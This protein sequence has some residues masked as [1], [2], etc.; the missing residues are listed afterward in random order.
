MC[1]LFMVTKSSVHVEAV[2]SW[3]LCLDLIYKYMLNVLFL[4]SVPK[5]HTEWTLIFLLLCIF[6]LSTL[7]N[8]V[9]TRYFRSN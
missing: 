7:E 3:D 4:L 9:P 5:S 6:P 8:N 1:F 2:N